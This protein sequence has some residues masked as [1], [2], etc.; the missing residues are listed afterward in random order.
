MAGNG[1]PMI[2]QPPRVYVLAQVWANADAARRADRI[3]SACPDAEVRTFAYRDLPDI[4]LEEG[5]SGAPRMGAMADVPPPIPV[6]TL[7]RFD[8]EAVKADAE[9][10]RAA[11]PDGAGFRWDVAAGGGAFVWFTSDQEELAPNREH[12]CRPQWRLHLGRGCPHQCRYCGLGGY[13]ISHLNVEDYIHH[14]ADLLRQNPWQK[15]WLYDDIMDVVALE[16]QWDTLPPL[17]RFFES[18]EDRYLIIHTK[19]ERW[20]PLVEAGAPRNTIIAWSLSGP[21]QSRQVEPVTGTTGSRIEAAR[22]CQTAGMQI[23]YKFKPIVPVRNWREEAT[24]TIDLALARTRPDNLSLTHLMWMTLADLRAC[25]PPV[26]LD[27]EFLRAAESAAGEVDSRVGPFPAEARE[28]VY[29]H[30]LSEIRARDAEVPVTVCTES[31][32]MWK[33]LGGELGF[34]PAT[35]VCGCGAGA[36]PGLKELATSPWQDARL[37]KTWDGRALY[38][39]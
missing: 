26:L 19:S 8:E 1:L 7:Y 6:L 27:P 18:S 29:R 4:V 21:T 33:R 39:G 15:T 25:I 20:Q 16:P 5:W 2:F 31:L 35:Y 28:T 10:M 14:L 11:C 34:T 36:T 37:A 3:C 12:V 23:R 38:Q 13:Q 9:R 30:Y 24:Y 32:E 17:M 22:Q